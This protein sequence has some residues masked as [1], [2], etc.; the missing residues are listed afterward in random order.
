M[1]FCQTLANFLSN[2]TQ[3]AY[4]LRPSVFDSFYSVKTLCSFQNETQSEQ[5]YHFISKSIF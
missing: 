4:V 2:V 1:E 3:I 5:L